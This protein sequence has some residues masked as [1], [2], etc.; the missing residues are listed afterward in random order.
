M[1]QGGGYRPHTGGSVLPGVPEPSELF[2]AWNWWFFKGPPSKESLEA[3]EK[4]GKSQDDCWRESNV[5]IEYPIKTAED[6]WTFYT[7]LPKPT[8]LTTNK[9]GFLLVREGC[10][11]EWEEP[12]MKQGGMWQFKVQRDVA[13][14]L[15][16]HLLMAVVG[17]MFAS[18]RL[19]IED[20]EIVAFQNEIKTTHKGKGVQDVYFKLWHK[21]ES[22]ADQ[23]KERLKELI[24][25]QK[26]G[27]FAGSVVWEQTGALALRGGGSNYD[28]FHKTNPN[29]GRTGEAGSPPPGAR[30]G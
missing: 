22:L 12:E 21:R 4:D 14:D 17:Q 1:P 10:R 27:K 9:Q 3:A 24:D 25:K 28:C 23:V 8:T 29:R 15:W 7:T 13:D 19:G 26:E 5:K 30:T 18:Q 11:A 20:D 2:H 6:F 16:K